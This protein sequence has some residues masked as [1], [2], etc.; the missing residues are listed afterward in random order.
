MSYKVRSLTTSDRVIP[1]GVIQ[2]LTERTKL[3]S[4]SDQLWGK[5]EI[6]G[7]GDNLLST[8]ERDTIEP[9]N[10]GESTIK[11]LRNLIHDSYPVNTR[12]WLNKYFDS[13]RTIY[14]FNLIP[15]WMTKDEWPVLGGFQNFLKD[16]LGG[17]I[18]AE[19]EGYYNED[20][21]YI[22]WQMYEGASGIIRAA[23]LNEKGEWVSY[24]LKINSEKAVN[25]F[26]H[27]ISPKRGFFS[28]FFGI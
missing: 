23:S 4:G 2:R 25:L 5:I 6:Y 26:K 13:V 11:E 15:D 1:F 20:G 21:D 16:S 9:G 27:G 17:I 7:A 8:L 18:Q 3:V 19:H 14:T 24:S 10:G 12:E 22:L 28:R